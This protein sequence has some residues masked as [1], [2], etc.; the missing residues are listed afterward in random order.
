MIR[1]GFKIA[2]AT[3]QQEKAAKAEEDARDAE[4]RKQKQVERAAMGFTERE[5]ELPLQALAKSDP[6]HFLESLGLI[7]EIREREISALGQT[8]KTQRHRTHR[9]AIRT[10]KLP[11]HSLCELHNHTPRGVCWQIHVFRPF[12]LLSR[13]QYRH[14]G[15][16]IRQSTMERPQRTTRE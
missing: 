8:R 16:P 5:G 6:S 14:R 10:G 2:I 3:G 15:T 4:E 11:N 1:T 7:P 12:L 13:I 9:L